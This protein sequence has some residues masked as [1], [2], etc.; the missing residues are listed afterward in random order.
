MPNRVAEGGGK[1]A[2]SA[3]RGPVVDSK[4]TFSFASC[5]TVLPCLGM[6][7]GLLEGSCGQHRRRVMR[8]HLNVDYDYE[9]LSRR[10]C[11]KQLRLHIQYQI[12]GKCMICA[13]LVIH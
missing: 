3:L 13:V 2:L 6:R 7:G 4:R 1:R 12:P 8:N 5:A 11:G 10:R 9:T